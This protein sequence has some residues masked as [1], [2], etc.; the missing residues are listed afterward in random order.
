MFAPNS[1]LPD[2]LPRLRGVSAAQTRSQMEHPHATVRDHEHHALATLTWEQLTV[3][4]KDTKGASRDVLKE[5]SGLALPGHLL[6]IMG[7]SGCGKSTLLDTLAGRLA[8]SATQTGAIKVNGHATQLNYG[9]CAYVT[10][11]EVLVGTMTVYETILCAAR[12]R[13]DGS[14]EMHAAVTEEVLSDL[15]LTE[16]RDTAIGNW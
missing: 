12:L 9:R 7:P 15:G 6:A 11:D 2:A 1:G 3:T 8:R 10:Q 13:L 14:A 16:V 4:V 5:V